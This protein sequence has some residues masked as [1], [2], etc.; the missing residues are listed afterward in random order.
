[1]NFLQ[2]IL[3]PLRGHGYRLKME[4]L[5]QQLIPIRQYPERELDV[6]FLSTGRC[7]THFVHNVLDRTTSAYSVHDGGMM[8]KDVYRATELWHEKPQAYKAVSLEDFP[9]A[10]TKILRNS[11]YPARVYV[12]LCHAMYPFG[13]MIWDYFRRCGDGRRAKIVHLVRE[14]VGACRSMLKVERDEE[15]GEGFSRRA[16]TIGQGNSSAEKA[17][18]VWNGINRICHEAIENI[19]DES[20]ARTQRI[21]DLDEAGCHDLFSFMEIEVLDWPRLTSMLS[22]R[23]QSLRHSHHARPEVKTSPATDDEIAVI[24]RDTAKVATMLGYT[25]DK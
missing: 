2:G 1:M 14:P 9:W 13:T 4:R 25:L 10:Y 5:R 22:D 12:E 23:R 18:S 11:R 21:E 16:P 6:Y 7:G 24:R 15:G 19:G 17:A 3:S 20:V 8:L